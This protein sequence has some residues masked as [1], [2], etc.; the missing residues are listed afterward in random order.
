MQT[1]NKGKI[2]LNTLFWGLILWIFGYILG[3]VFFYLVPKE[4]IG[5]YVMPFGIIATIWVLFKKIKRDS[6]GCYVG[7]GVIWT[8]L[9]I[10]LDYFF[11]VKLFNTTSYY[12]L[13]VYIYYILAFSLPIFVGWYKIKIINNHK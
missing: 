2:L 4:V 5:W 3:F 1:N 11:I 13:D 7:L 10:A 12:K 9:A 8:I 6:F